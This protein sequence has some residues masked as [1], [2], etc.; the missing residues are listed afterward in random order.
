MISGTVS[1]R[2]ARIPLLLSRPQA[3]QQQV[4]AV[5]DT[6]YTAALSLPP[7]QIAALN[8]AWQGIGRGILADGSEC[9]FDVDEAEVMWDGEPRRLLVD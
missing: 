1:D 8:L 9:L 3:T 4:E 6:G 2:E 5:I 7:Q